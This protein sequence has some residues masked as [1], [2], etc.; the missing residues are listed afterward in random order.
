MV[1][2]FV[3][4]FCYV[5]NPKTKPFAVPWKTNW[6]VIANKKQRGW[7]EGVDQLRRIDIKDRSLKKQGKRKLAE[8]AKKK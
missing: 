6:T 8:K 5:A 1:F 2:L 7:C 3:L 4:L